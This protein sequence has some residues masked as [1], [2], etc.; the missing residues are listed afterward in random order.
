[1]NKRFINENDLIKYVKK[2]NGL[3]ITRSIINVNEI[4]NSLSNIKV[5]TNTL[6]VCLTGYQ[7]II[8][9]FFNKI[10]LDIDISVIL[11]IIET[12]F[13]ELTDQDANNRKIKQIYCWNKPFNHEKLTSIPIGL[14]YK[15]QYNSIS[16]FLEN[17]NKDKRN[18]KLL[19][20][21]YSPHTNSIRNKLIEK[22]KL[23]WIN[24]CDIVEN[25]DNERV[26][27]ADSCIEGKIKIEVTNPKYYELISNYKFILSPPGAGIDCHR[28]WEACYTGVIPIVI[29]SNISELY[30]NLPICVVDSWDI[31]NEEYLNKKYEEI[32]KNIKEN[33]YEIDKLY[34]DYWTN[35]ISLQ[36]NKNNI[37]FITYGNDKFKLAKER[38]L[39]EA[40]HFDVFNNIK[41]Y[42]PEDLPNVF[43]EKYK[44]I[45]MNSRGGGYWLWRPLII[46]DALE[47]MNDNEFLV[48]LDAGCVI[49]KEGKERFLEYIDLLDKNKNNYGIMSFQMSGNKGPGN[50]EKEKC[51]T[52]KQIFD[53]FD[54]EPESEI[55]NSGQ[56]LGGILIMK[57][58]EH[59]KNYMKKYIQII[60]EKPDL[61]SDIYNNKNQHK[62]FR[63]NRHEQSITSIL[64]KIEGSVVI[65][66]DESFMQPFGKG[67]SLKY[68]F[69]AARLRK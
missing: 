38:I 35:K 10:L 64:R 13:F 53:Y 27:K 51:W 52:I 32:Q 62:Y 56:Y 55:G 23:D 18:K 9:N 57:K 6:L 65:D 1:M 68:P 58:N 14:N 7:N 60:L 42:G 4:M 25:I 43:Y 29:K 47:K 37:N 5:H 26:Y 3:L 50:L 39:K 69:W 17:Q 48:Y 31:I 12:D 59:L 16:K 8:N 21:N 40:L 11:I 2:E 63:E 61:C 46:H 30:N 34:L 15:R 66:G 67:E 22:A 49:N 28:T 19:C 44:N 36:K 41:G 45:L 54:I 24:F 20:I 33:K